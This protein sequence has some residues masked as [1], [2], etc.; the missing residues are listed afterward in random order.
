MKNRFRNKFRRRFRKKNDIY[1]SAIFISDYG[2]S[3]GNRNR[4]IDLYE[5]RGYAIIPLYLLYCEIVFKILTVRGVPVLSWIPTI[6]FPLVIGI[7]ISPLGGLSK[8]SG[9]NRIVKNLI[10]LFFGILFLISFFIYKQFKVYYDL[11]TVIN[12][13]G[14]VVTQFMDH[15][16]RLIFSFSG[17]L[18]I[19]LYLAPIILYAIFGSKIDDANRFKK[20]FILPFIIAVVLASVIN[21]PVVYGNSALRGAYGSRYNF[22]S[23]VSDF[24]LLTGM[25]LDIQKRIKR[26]S[27][28]SENIAE[29]DV[30]GEI[31]DDEKNPE[32]GDNQSDG[33]DKPE[34]VY[35]ES[36]MDIDFLKLSDSASNSR[37]ADLDLYVAR[38]NPSLQNEYTGLF[39]G[40]NLIMICAEAFSYRV[41]DPELTPTLYRLSTKG[42][43]F[44]DYI[45]QAS[46]GTIG[47]EYQ[48]IF[49]LMPSEGGASFRE[50]SD[51]L[52]WFTM[53][54][55][56]TR[57][58]YFG[59]PFHNGEYTYYDRN[60]THNSI[61]YSDEYLACGNG[62]EELITD[63]WP[64]S[65][66]EMIQQTLPMYIDKTPFNAYYMSVSGHSIYTREENQMSKKNWSYVE[67]LDYSDPV[68]AYI[69][70]NLELEFALDYLV[71]ELTEKGIADD[72]VIVLTADHFP[73]G[74]D[75]DAYIG[76]MPLLSELYGQE[77]NDY[78]T[79]D[80][81]RLIIWSG[82][83]EKMDPI[84]IDAP[85]SCLD[86]LPTLSNLF[87]LDWDSRLLPGRDVLSGAT[88]LV[89]N[90]GYD[91]KTDKGSY[92]SSKDE[93]TPLPGVT[94][95]SDYVARVNAV[96]RGKM[97]FCSEVLAL[98]YYRHVIEDSGYTDLYHI[99]D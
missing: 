58:G 81:N 85:T 86:V 92:I 41:I 83:L 43:N 55:Q 67:N 40:K 35:S 65:D 26:D 56:L 75:D 51:N 97:D 87:G 23:A 72:T 96:V 2:G 57:E 73:Y 8:S 44:N 70:A 82:T 36:V 78:M 4:R 34:K 25:R 68:K 46:A 5:M 30:D 33:D 38:Q 16:F 61:G 3:R 20:R 63:E 74:L 11:P 90:S 99:G 60:I 1:Y 79:R 7:I 19:I 17:V 47:G 24:G 45:Q 29:I 21:L 59:K 37:L 49:G 42:I 9:A 27:S 64:R 15:V 66:L 31:A 77:V 80:K 6:L 53:G 98:D 84:I 69:A 94:V 13:A 48:F 52:T 28:I 39:K 95:D 50:M 18:A 10:M 62:L 22:Q 89:F 93:F 76:N 54:S 14:G 12:G 91:W 32:K 88:P 71:K